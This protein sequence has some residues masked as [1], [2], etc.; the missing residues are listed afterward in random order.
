VIGLFG[1]MEGASSDLRTGLPSQMIEIH[2]PMRLQV[3]VE[4]K[5]AVLEHIYQRQ[6][7]LRELIANGWIHLHALDP[8]TGDISVFE[9]GKGF[10]RWQ[11]E[12]MP[13]LTVENS[14]AAYLDQ[15]G[16]VAPVLIRQAAGA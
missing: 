2:E 6:A 14:Q 5:T 12:V 11:G 15:T 4:A 13:I 9:R 7:S 16:P 1:V 3:I 8:E 10:V